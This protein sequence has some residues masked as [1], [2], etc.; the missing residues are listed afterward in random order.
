MPALPAEPDRFPE[1]LFEELALAKHSER[2][3]WVMHTR[4][5]QEKSLARELHQRRIPYYLPLYARRRRFRTKIVTCYVPLFTSYLFLLADREERIAG[6]AT[7]RVV[8]SLQVVAQE[9]LWRDLSQINRLLASGADVRPEGRL[10][11]GDFVEIQSGPLAG[12][13]GQILKSASGSRFVVK[14]DFIQRGASVLLDDF[15]M[16]RIELKPKS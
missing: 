16:T 15:L 4:P 13:T 10:Q 6:L 1:E 5:R 2:A 14:V 3:W 12:L 8:T 9:Q 11:P 7:S